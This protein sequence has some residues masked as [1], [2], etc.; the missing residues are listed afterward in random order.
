[1]KQWI[2]IFKNYVIKINEN[3]KKVTNKNTF[4]LNTISYSTYGSASN[5]HRAI[6]GTA[7][8]VKLAMPQFPLPSHALRPI[9]Y[10]PCPTRK[11]KKYFF[12]RRE[13]YINKC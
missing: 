11:P 6:P 1:M 2:I 9:K 7:W 5:L 10:I 13:L 8:I 4:D 3:L 12:L